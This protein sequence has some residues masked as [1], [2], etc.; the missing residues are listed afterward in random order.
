LW[1]VA[2]GLGLSAVNAA[3]PEDGLTSEE[4]AART[5]AGR[6]NRATPEGWKPY[7]DIVRRNTLTLFNALVAPAAAALFLLRDYRGAWAVSAMAAA[8]ALLGLTHELRAKIHLERLS[9]LSTATVRVRRDGLERDILSTEVV[10]GD[11]IELASGDTVPADGTLVAS[12]FL[13]M[14]EAL[15][16]GESDP[17]PRVVGDPVRSGSVCVAGRGAFLAERVGDD[18]FALRTAAAARKYRHAPGP[19]QRT[20]DRLVQGLTALAVFLCLGYA[21]LY[22]VRGFPVIDLVQMVSA[23]ITSMVPQGLALMAT[24]AFVLAAVRLGR[25]GALIQRLAAVEG[26]AT[27]DVLCMDKTGTLTTGRLTLD[28]IVSFTEPDAEVRK[29]LGAYAAVSVDHSNKNIAALQAELGSETPRAEALEQWPFHSRDRFSAA[30]VQIADERR[31]LVL[32]SYESLCDRF[33]DSDRATVEA[34]WRKLLPTGLR[35]LAFADGEAEK[36]PV[37]RNLSSLPLRPL[38]LIALRDELRADAADV[39]AEF[40]GQGISLKIVSGDN[41]ETVSA[42][43]RSLGAMFSTGAPTTGEEWEADS[44]RDDRAV[45]GQVFGRMS[46]EQKLAL[47]ESL[48]RRGWS[49]GMIGDGVN[50]ILP[51]KRA[52]FGVAM[53]AGSPATKAAADLVLAAN[54][55]AALPN[56]LAEGRSVVTAIRQAAKLFLLKNAYTVALVLVAVGICGLPFPYLPQQ[57]TLLNALTIG[58]PAVLILAGRSPTTHPVGTGFFRDVGRFVLVAGVATSVVGLTVYLSATFTFGYDVE[59]A[60]TLL[61]STLILAGVGNAV[62]ATHGD[63]RLVIWGAFAVAALATVMAVGPFVYF[64]A[65]TPPSFTQWASILFA[66]ACVVGSTAAFSEPARRADGNRRSTADGPTRVSRAA[67]EPPQSRE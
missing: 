57:V 24:L 33:P 10:E 2:S 28:R 9:L 25:H 53:G 61:L 21:V 47:V 64:F 52:D 34:E 3:S 42:T 46:P 41:P 11:R 44:D 50:D 27:I 36:L 8:N 40:A 6:S 43:V 23:T 45:R 63:R 17:V 31:L 55:F 65:L 18:A 14:D 5:A 12:E 13:E 38:T 54:D 59:H 49:V 30:V 67:S 1:S 32:G 26:L 48:Q 16:T 37:V 19:T 66:A 51:I 39:L 62:L 4:A 58:G 56:V 29:W 20:L 7:V 60:R 15:L 22:F 35:L